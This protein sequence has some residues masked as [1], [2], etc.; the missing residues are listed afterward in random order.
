MARPSDYTAEIAAAICDR[1]IGGESVRQIADSPDMPGQRT[2]YQWLQK[3]DEFAQ[4]YARAREAQA[5]RLQDEIISIADDGTNDTYRDDDGNVRT[6]H[7]VVAR[8]RLRVDTRKWLM[9]KLAPKKYGD[10]VTNEHTGKD[11]TPLT[12][13]WLPTQ[14]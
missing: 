12:V 7:D 5:E 8:S 13:T 4:Q 14:S 2:I 3:H 1:I 10:K 6:D 11:G 9:S